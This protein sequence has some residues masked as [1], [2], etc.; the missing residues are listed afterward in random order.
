MRI[1][2]VFIL[3]VLLSAP[4]ALADV[5][6][7]ESDGAPSAPKINLPYAFYNSSFGASVAYIYGRY[8]FPQKQS[9]VFGTVM[10]GTA[11]SGMLL[12][13]GKDIRLFGLK[14]LAVDPVILLGYFG[15][16]ETYIGGNPEFPDERSGSH[17]S[18]PENSIQGKGW[19]N[20]FR[21]RF[22]FL[23]PLGHGRDNIDYAYRLDRG[24][25]RSGASGGHSLNPFTSGR[26][27]VSVS[28]F[29][30]S[31]SVESDDIPDKEI[32]TNGIDLD[33]NWDNRD[34]LPSPSKG[35]ALRLGISRDFGAFGSSQSWTAWQG[36]LDAYLDLGSNGWLRQAVIACDL[37]TAH[38]PS[39]QVAESGDI[40][41]NPPPFAG[42]SLGGMW[43]MRG[44]V[45]QRYNDRSAIY[46][47]LELRLIPEWNPFDS[48]GWLQNRLGIQWV[49]FVPFVEIGRVATNW[50]VDELHN[51][52]NVDA[53]LGVRIFAKGLVL[54]IDTAVTEE[55]YGVRMMV[56]QPFHF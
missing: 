7:A 18:D 3:C 31:L 26:T 28:P 49:Q 32:N 39:W 47:C 51:D 8:G 43:R 17:N 15:E 56:G 20:L 1:V 48:W 4:Y 27:I 40:S 36:E 50:A 33:L 24:L 45:P 44:Y 11:G 25:L 9:M 23:L 21:F 30:R 55:D 14:R 37:W 54:R 34:F 22:N 41:S 19:D 10:T 2:A 35:F 5:P 16:A 12:L 13:M 42:A 52:M 6:S 46:Y 53:G 29:Y 38:S